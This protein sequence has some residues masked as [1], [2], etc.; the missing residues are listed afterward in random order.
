MPPQVGVRDPELAIAGERL[1]VDQLRNQK[2]PRKDQEEAAEASKY[3]G[4]AELQLSGNIGG[5]IGPGECAG[6]R[7]HYAQLVAKAPDVFAQ[8]VK[9]LDHMRAFQAATACA[10]FATVTKM[11]RSGMG[12]AEMSR[13]PGKRA[14]ISATVRSAS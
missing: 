13:A 11:E 3:R 5:G 9:S 1:L 14:R 6:E 8:N 12:V 10:A 4:A 7:R 2:P